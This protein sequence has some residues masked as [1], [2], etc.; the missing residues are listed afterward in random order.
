MKQIP[1]AELHLVTQRKHN[2]KKTTEGNNNDILILLLFSSL[3]YVYIFLFSVLN[4]GVGSQFLALATG[5]L[6]MALFGMFNVHRHG[7]INSAAIV[8]YALTSGKH[9][10][11]SSA[12]II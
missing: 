1:Y 12:S 6:L 2:K 7:S 5:I 11:I 4:L 10:F 9:T 8:L 3:A